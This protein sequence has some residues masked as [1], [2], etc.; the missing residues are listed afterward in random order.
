MGRLWT[1]KVKVLLYD[2]REWKRKELIGTEQTDVER[3]RGKLGGHGGEKGK[4]RKGGRREAEDAKLQL[5]TCQR[6]DSR[7]DSLAII[8]IKLVHGAE[9]SLAHS[10]D[11]DGHGKA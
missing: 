11:D 6:R 2:Q 7:V 4:N 3:Q 10:N 8:S 9:V 5:A 1:N